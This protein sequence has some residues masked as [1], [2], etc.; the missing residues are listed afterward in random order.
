VVVAVIKSQAQ[1]VVAVVERAVAD[2]PL[3]F[4]L[5]FIPLLAIMP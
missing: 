5:T 2:N 3:T 1:R 4:T